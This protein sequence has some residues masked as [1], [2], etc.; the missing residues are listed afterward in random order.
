MCLWNLRS[1]LVT[2]FK[3]QELDEVSWCC[4]TDTDEEL[5]IDSIFG[6][7]LVGL[8]LVVDSKEAQLMV[9]TA[10]IQSLVLLLRIL[11]MMTRRE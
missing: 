9:S 6:L 4:R 3:N 8:D 1:V 7:R 10:T 2:G 11:E 5:E